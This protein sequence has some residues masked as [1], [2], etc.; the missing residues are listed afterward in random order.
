[1]IKRSGQGKWIQIE[2]ERVVAFSCR[3][4]A[5]WEIGNKNTFG[6]L[7][8]LLPNMNQKLALAV[9]TEMSFHLIEVLFVVGFQKIGLIKNAINLVDQKSTFTKMGLAFKERSVLIIL[10][11]WLIC[12]LSFSLQVRYLRRDFASKL[13][14]A[15]GT[16]VLSTLAN[17]LAILVCKLSCETE[18]YSRLSQS[19]DNTLSLSRHDYIH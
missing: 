13:Q 15:I 2:C 14:W 7:I 12:L 10:K 3:Q 17:S 8:S 16:T 9:P 1:M 5:P 11:I 18:Y 19:N 4:I 6:K